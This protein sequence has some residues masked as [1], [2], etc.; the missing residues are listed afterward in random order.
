MNL[1][2][3]ISAC[4]L[5]YTAFAQAAELSQHDFLK[6]VDEVSVNN[7]DFAAASARHQFTLADISLSNRLDAP[8][9]AFGHIWGQRGI[10]TKWHLEASQSFE[11][12]GLYRARS[13]ANQ[14]LSQAS[15]ASV[16]RS[17]Y[18]TRLSVAQ[19]LIDVI[20]YRKLSAL[21]ADN[22]QRVDSLLSLYQRGYNMG[23]ISILDVNKLKIERISANRALQDAL[24]NS[25]EAEGNLLRLNG[26]DAQSIKTILPRLT[27]FPDCNLVPPASYVDW[28][29][30]NNPE[31]LYIQSQEKV[32]EAQIKVAQ[33]SRY[34]GFSLALTHDYELGDHF[35][36]FSVGITLPF[37]TAGKNVESARLNAIA[38]QAEAEALRAS[39]RAST[40]V[41]YSKALMLYDEQLQ[42]SKVLADDQSVR[43]LNL[44]LRQGQITLI[45]YMLQVNFFTEA[46]ATYITTRYQYL[47][48]AM[49]LNL[50]T[51]PADFSTH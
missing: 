36:G 18:I 26:D 13:R 12:P 48:A 28:A 3:I 16:A 35:N 20:Y 21:Y 49:A 1:K 22:L 19:A 30:T 33:Q 43:L 32:A 11:W 44:A 41:M 17:L 45:D 39:L 37:L 34:P 42:Y 5:L 29:Q 6:I 47:L 25:V 51:L 46:Q 23:E 10:G 14:L 9:L 24:Q 40:E 7:K 8:Q 27:E 2:I 4:A 15:A 38:L 50:Q 31:L